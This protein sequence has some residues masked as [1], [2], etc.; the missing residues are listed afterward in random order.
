MHER[1]CQCDQISDSI[2]AA[3]TA[4]YTNHEAPAGTLAP[5]LSSLLVQ[6]VKPEASSGASA[7]KQPNELKQADKPLFR[8]SFP[9][10]PPPP[11]PLPVAL[12]TSSSPSSPGRPPPPP[13]EPA[14]GNHGAG[15][16]ADASA[17][18]L[19]TSM[20]LGSS[21]I[22]I[23]LD[24]SEPVA[25]EAEPEAWSD[26]GAAAP[27]SMGSSIATVEQHAI[28][29]GSD[30]ALSSAAP[31]ATAVLPVAFPMTP[32]DRYGFL[33]TDKRFHKAQLDS[34]T[35]KSDVWLE[36]R[37]TQKWVKMIGKQPEDWEVCQLKNATKLKQ[38]I[39]KG[40]PEA[41][42]GRVWCHLAGSTQMLINNPGVYRELVQK[43]GC[44][45][46]ETISRD[47]GR[48]FPKHYLFRDSGSLGQH[49]LMNVLKA[50]AMQDVEVGYCQGM[51]FLTAMFLSYMPEEQAFWHLVA[52]L[53]HKRYD[54][55][56]LYRPRM[57]KV[58]ELIYVFEKLMH[59]TMPQLAK[60]LEDEGL[61]P[62]IFPF[63][64]VKRVWDVYLNEGWKVIFRVALALMKVSQKTLLTL[65][66]EAM[67]EFFRELPVRVNVDEVLDVAFKLSLKRSE[68]DALKEEYLQSIAKKS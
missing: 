62:T 42:R 41:L 48:T 15:A 57:P 56:N 59:S 55:A 11:P 17:T 40:I 60:H 44:V 24:A 16:G 12:S 10:P 63:E 51:G 64:F 1:S 31:A 52:C 38:R 36:N 30:D 28:T 4:M 3:D 43:P 27:V 21:E 61:H 22:D 20:S 2:G 29:V 39:R 14:A 67:M 53:N 34:P 37:R 35:R 6:V 9:P 32:I 49:A 5:A 45:C 8:L 46:E 33:V 25:D 50:Y 23:Q 26:T 66:F 7:G 54:M 65:K 68:L 19:V 18:G 13:S 47:I 58:P